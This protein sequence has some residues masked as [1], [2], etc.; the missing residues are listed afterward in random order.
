M[1]VLLHIYIQKRAF[2]S[3]FGVKAFRFRIASEWS[4]LGRYCFKRSQ[5][6]GSFD[7]WR[8]NFRVFDGLVQEFKKILTSVKIGV[9]CCVLLE[10]DLVFHL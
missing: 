2:H 1:P 6:G 4:V 7:G 8:L 5:W 9:N 3:R 10:V